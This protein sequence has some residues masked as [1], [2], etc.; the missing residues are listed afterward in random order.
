MTTTRPKR[1]AITSVALAIGTALTLSGCVADGAPEESSG[2]VTLTFWHSADGATAEVVDTIVKEFNDAHDGQITVNAT[3]Q[4][5]YDDTVAKLSASVQAGDLP[6]L[7]QINDVNTA[8]M[9]DSGLVAP[10]EQLLKDAAVDY[11]FGTLVPAVSNYYTV[12][13]A[14]SSMPFQVSQPAVFVRDDVLAATGTTPENFPTTVS[15]LTKWAEEAKAATG[16]AGLTFHINPWW[17]E[18]LTAGAGIEYCNP[19]NGRGGDTVDEFTTADDI[20]VEQWTALQ[21]LFADGAA[22][23]VG[24]D[25]SAG[26]NALSAGEAGAFFSSSGALGTVTSAMTTDWSVVPFPVEGDEGGVAPGGNSVF[27]LKDSLSSDAEKAA[28]AEFLAYLG[29]DEVQEQSFAATGFLP[30]TDAAL[31]A[32]KSNADAH[33][34]AL[35]D[36]LANTSDSV[37]AAGCLS[38]A[39]QAVRGEL[40]PALEKIVQG[41]DVKSTLTAVHDSATGLVADYNERA[42]Q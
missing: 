16:K 18:E 3:Y 22:L 9:I 26:V 28:A 30:T 14:L 17:F 19:D 11:D 2:P 21:Q 23:N 31:A 6:D 32:S 4:G 12:D 33:Q 39:L 7:V 40:T 36:Q 27:A 5:K 24:T 41:D 13:G 15:G 25:F 34:T 10:A 29:S 8:F 20:Q 35:L 37:A 38:G 42:G 1:L